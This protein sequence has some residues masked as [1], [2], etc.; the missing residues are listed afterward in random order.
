MPEYPYYAEL[1]LDKLLI[2]DWNYNEMSDEQQALLEDNIQRVGFLDPILVVPF[3]PNEDG[4]VF[5][6]IIDG[7]H[8]YEMLRMLNHDTASCIVV[9]PAV[10][11]EKTRMLQTARAN[12]IKGSPNQHRMKQFIKTMVEKHQVGEAELHF[13]MG[14]ADINEFEAL[15]GE[16]REALPRDKQVREE[17]DRRAKNAKTVAELQA[18]V[19]S[20]YNK[21]GNTAPAHF[22]IVD[23]GHKR[24]L[25]IQCPPSALSLITE[26]F[27][28]CMEEGYTVSSLLIEMLA[29]VDIPTFVR[30]RAENLQRIP[31]DGP[32]EIDEL[33]DIQGESEAG[34]EQVQVV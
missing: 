14:F 5:Y 16:Y 29:T 31:N 4:V 3:P 7:E 28:E 19:E 12:H 2:N 24:H 27:K 20:L 6:E 33:L 26:K 23:C 11:D 30:E 25:W 1:E 13:E 8:R 15:A 10:F 32:T 18:I 22:M 9:D 21:Y 34:T 17:F